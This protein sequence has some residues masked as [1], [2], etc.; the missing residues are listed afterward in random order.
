MVVSG[1]LRQP[2]CAL[3]GS[4][5]VEPAGVKVSRRRL[6][7]NEWRGYWVLSHTRKGRSVRC[8]SLDDVTLH[9]TCN[10]DQESRRRDDC[11]RNDSVDRQGGAYAC[12]ENALTGHLVM[13]A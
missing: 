1:M 6:V 10:M 3:A 2:A 8:V 9:V 7:R 13:A 12:V 11:E 4:S 5:R